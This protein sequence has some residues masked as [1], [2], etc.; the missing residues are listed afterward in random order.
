MKSGSSLPA[1]RKG[2]RVL[3]LAA[4]LLCGALGFS[5]LAGAEG[6]ADDRWWG[7]G[8]D[9]TWPEVLDYP[10]A[11]GIL[12]TLI[13][14]GPVQ[15]KGHPFFEPMGPNG[16]A[17][18]SCHQPADAMSLAVETIQERWRVT[19]GTDPIF[20]AYDG[21]NC[22]VLPQGEAASHSMLL[23]HGLFRIERPWPITE[24]EGR[25]VTP[26]FTIEVV[27]DPHGCNSGVQYGPENGRIS[28]YRRP[29]PLANL[30][31][32]L[33]VGFAYDPKQGLTLPRD[34]D[35]GEYLSGNLMSD[36]RAVNLR[37]QMEDAAST[38]GEM[39]DRL[40]PA[41]IQA[42]TAFNLSVFTAQQVGAHGTA[43]D[44]LGATGGPATL[45]DS[46]AGALG[47]IGV[48][49]FSEFA[50]WETIAPEEAAR[51]S[52]EQLEWRRSVARGARVFRDKT[53][54]ITDS[55]GIN[56]PM[57]FG[58]PVR[59]SCVFCHNMTRMGN[60]V[61][62]GQVD[63]GTTTLPF[64]DPLPDFPLFRITCTGDPHPHYGRVIL[65]YDP[66]FAL[67]SGRCA[68]VGKITLQSLRGLSARAPYF[69]NGSAKDLEGVVDYYERRYNI[70]YT[71]QER[72]DLINLMSA[73]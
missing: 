47:S 28:V 71:A 58:N 37:L 53:F 32:L 11:N 23:E 59:N 46:E 4:G 31:Y 21:S 36:N 51:L 12:R 52:P 5:G 14:G 63:L 22:P 41:A 50:V 9:R 30:K 1:P 48:P 27:R 42:I 44:S 39:I 66:G 73:L 15:T 38:H 68:D 55:A 54:L 49:V 8:E 16:R 45:R 34:P 61:A 18:I 3:L 69:A 60:D 7:P 2:K 33:A 13:T 72:Q 57:G 25:A 67:T 35:T 20:A 19:N 62:P 43:L 17:C 65:T 26:D 64:A 6:P 40:S 29:R 24:Y 10:N 70:G 56:S